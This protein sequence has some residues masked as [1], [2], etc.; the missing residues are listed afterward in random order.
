MA[1]KEIAYI[2]N[3]ELEKL[4]NQ[5]GKLLFNIQ[6]PLAGKN[7]N[8][9][10]TF[11]KELI[12]AHSKKSKHKIK[13]ELPEDSLVYSNEDLES[14]FLDLDIPLE[15][16]IEK[17]AHY[18]KKK[19]SDIVICVL[20]RPRHNSIFKI[21]KKKKCKKFLISD[22]DIFGAIS[23]AIKKFNIDLYIG[24]GGAPEGVLAA[25][26]LKSLGGQMQCRLIFKDK[27][28]KKRALEMGLRNL[29]KK[30]QIKDLIKNDAIFVATGVTNGYLL[31]GIKK[32]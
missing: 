9:L 22:G 18:K 12:K 31:N 20:D 10:K 15:T 14:T 32:K 26:V 28:Q 5:T 8:L 24:I 1:T 21:I 30:Y 25:T 11:T 4:N 29:K 16:T 17:L 19:V 3:K 23:T 27:F 6:H 2:Y 7:I 13:R